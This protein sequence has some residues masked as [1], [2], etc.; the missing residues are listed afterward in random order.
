MIRISCDS[1]ADLSAELYERYNIS[2]LPLY[3]NIVGKEYSDGIDIF[4]TRRML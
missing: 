1:T 4:P 3:I 2:R